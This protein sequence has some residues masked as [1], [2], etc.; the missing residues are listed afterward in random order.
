MAEIPSTEGEVDF[1]VEG[2]GKQCKKWYKIFGEFPS[3][4]GIPPLIVLHGG[5][6]VPHNTLLPLKHLVT[7]NNVPV[8]L[9]NQIGCGQSTHLPEKRGDEFF[10]TV[11][12]FLNELENLLKYLG[13]TGEYDLDGHSAGGVLASEWEVRRPKGLRR[14]VLSSTLATKPLLMETMIK[15]RSEL[16]KETQDILIKHEDDGTL[17]S[18]E[19][20]QA[21]MLFASKH[22]LR[23]TPLPEEFLASM[24]ALKEDNTVN[25]TM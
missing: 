17:D 14:L 8:I 13:I 2:A 20:Q 1:H 9:Y 11:D 19:Y 10:W 12:L 18:P 22:M 25:F 15:L 7:T 4:M 16:P 24:K 23:I 5:P 6:G 3:P 21:N